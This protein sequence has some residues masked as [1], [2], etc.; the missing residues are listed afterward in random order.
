MS[1]VRVLGSLVLA[2]LVA[3]CPENSAPGNDREAELAPPEPPAEVSSVGSAIGGVA[4]GLLIP[5]T[6][7][8]ADLAN[9]PD[10]EVRCQFRFT[11][12]GL[13]IV[14]YGSAAVLKLNGK[15]VPL[16]ATGDGRYA[17]DGVTVTVRPLEEETV[18]GEPFATEFVLRLPE[19]SDEL[20]Y[21]GYST[22]EPS[23]AG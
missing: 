5:Q 21:H 20:G 7:T 10:V 17:A 13:P 11:T 2:L 12:V 9:L 3:G 15:L 22:C 8:E 14:A 16:P 19:A 1:R 23:A 4:T 6:M 18:D